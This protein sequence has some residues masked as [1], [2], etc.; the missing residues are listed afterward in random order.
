MLK[1]GTKV[2]VGEQEYIIKTTTEECLSC[3]VCALRN[4]AHNV[5]FLKLKAENKVY[6]CAKL[7]GARRH[8][9]KAD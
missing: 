5:D 9:A 8:F 2:K 1:V 3:S 4:C 6:S 7:I